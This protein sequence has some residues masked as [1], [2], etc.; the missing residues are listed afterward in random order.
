MLVVLGW[1]G[2]SLCWRNPKGVWGARDQDPGDKNGF[3]HTKKVGARVRRFQAVKDFSKIEI[4]EWKMCS[5]ES[6]GV[7]ISQCV[8]EGTWKVREMSW[9]WEDYQSLEVTDDTVSGQEQ[10]KGVDRHFVLVGDQA[11]AKGKMVYS[12]FLG[13]CEGEI[14]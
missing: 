2:L 8:I 1:F 7:A 6:W 10:S 9:T 5:D 4:W 14:L 3:T 13:I 11:E 12:S